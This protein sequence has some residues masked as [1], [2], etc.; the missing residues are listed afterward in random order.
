M[1]ILG[2]DISS[3]STGWC[4]VVKED[5]KLSLPEYGLVKPEG[6]MSSLQRL[7][8]F[9]NELSKI[10]DKHTPDE[11][12]IEETVLVRSPKVMRALSRFS[13][14][15]LFLAYKY[16]K[17]EIATYEPTMWMKALG[18]KGR[19]KKPEIQLSICNRFGLIDETKSKEYLDEI[20]SLHEKEKMIRDLDGSLVRGLEKEIDEAERDLKKLKAALR[21][22]GKKEVIEENKKKVEGTEVS[23]KSKKEELKVEK[24]KYNTGLKEIEKSF[25][26]ISVDIYS[27]SGI[28]HDIADSIGVGLKAA[29]EAE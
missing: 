9:G 20:A 16:Q 17:R 27:D 22:K 21:K 29:D 15:A 13:G 2:L 3:T 28:N 24:K 11:I 5:G 6:A 8:F 23:I 19:A 12:A 25:M 1:K 10:I 18:L 26:K 4:I 7:Y 14:V